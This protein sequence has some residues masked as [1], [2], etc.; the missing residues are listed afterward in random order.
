VG[1]VTGTAALPKIKT[2]VTRVINIMH[3]QKPSSLLFTDFLDVPHDP[4]LTCHVINE[5]LL[6]L[7][8]PVPPNLL[9][10]LNNTSKQNKNSTVLVYLAMLVLLGVFT[11]VTVS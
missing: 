2:H 10:Q 3:G 7:E 5:S 4:N 9:L 11:T 6:E 1:F 8:G